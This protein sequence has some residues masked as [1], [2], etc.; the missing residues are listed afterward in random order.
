MKTSIDVVDG[1][2]RLECHGAFDANTVTELIGKVRGALLT[3]PGVTQAIV[4]TS[5]ITECA[6]AAKKELVNLQK[7]LHPRIR[8]SAWIDERARFRG[9]AL[10]VMHLAGDQNAKAVNSLEAA[11]VWLESKE[12]RDS[13]RGVVTA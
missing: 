9:V 2:L 4:V 7:A 3:H 11:R 13:G 1:M 8:R 5:G 6:E 12:L 10:W